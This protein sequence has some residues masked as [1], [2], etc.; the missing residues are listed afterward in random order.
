M[1]KVG[2][3]EKITRKHNRCHEG[4]HS[5]VKVSRHVILWLTSLGLLQKGF[6]I[7]YKYNLYAFYL[8]GVNANRMRI[9]C[10]KDGNWSK[11]DQTNQTPLSLGF[12]RR[13]I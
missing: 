1:R 13:I 2:T 6:C 3:Y 10:I 12:S 11:N 9:D 5:G 4:I 8:R 7:H